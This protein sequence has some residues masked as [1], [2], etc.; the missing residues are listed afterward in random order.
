MT[1]YGTAHFV[2]KAA[3]ITYDQPYHYEDVVEAVERKLADGE[4]H[5]GAPKLKPG[6]RLLIIDEGTRYAIEEAS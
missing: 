2:S 6:E 5:I 3:A 4:I 1:R